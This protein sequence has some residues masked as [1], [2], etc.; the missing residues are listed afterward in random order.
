L[1]ESRLE[2]PVSLFC[3]LVSSRK[4]T[5]MDDRRRTLIFLSGLYGRW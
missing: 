5:W 2:N 3:K 4:Y 1:T